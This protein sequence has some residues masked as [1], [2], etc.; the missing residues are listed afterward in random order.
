M[1]NSIA[2]LWNARHSSLM[3]TNQIGLF[4]LI[5]V[6]HVKFLLKQRGREIRLGQMN[7]QQQQ[8]QQSYIPLAAQSTRK[9]LNRDMVSAL[10][11]RDA[12]K[13]LKIVGLTIPDRKQARLDKLYAYFEDK[14]PGY[15]IQS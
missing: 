12:V 4:G 13:W 5:R 2:D 10:S 1:A 9:F 14:P 15:R 6:A 8:Q 3:E 11:A 7:Q